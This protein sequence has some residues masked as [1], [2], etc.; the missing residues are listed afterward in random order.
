VI[1][2]VAAHGELVRGRDGIYGPPTG[3]WARLRRVFE[4]VLV[5]ARVR[6]AGVPVGWVR[7]DRDEVTVEAVST[8]DLAASIGLGR[9]CLRVARAADVALL[10]APS[11]IASGLRA[12]LRVVRRPF[13]VELLDEP[14]GGRLRRAVARAELRETVDAA[15]ATRF[16]TTTYLQQQFPPRAGRF[17]VAAPEVD[18]PDEL[19]DA[20]PAPIRSGDTLDLAFVGGFDDRAE[21]LELLITALAYTTR[22]HQ[23]DVAGDGPLRKDL[24]DFARR[25][26]VGQQLSFRGAV[27]D[28]RGFL[29]SRDLFVSPAATGVIPPTL[30]LAMAVRLPCVATRVGAVPELLAETETVPLGEPVAMAEV[31]DAL[32]ADAPRRGL[33][34]LANRRTVRE[35]RASEREIRLAAFLRALRAAG[36]QR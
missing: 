10:Q 11:P 29:R 8:D 5:L 20:P 28:V 31:I 24:V 7:V 27:L 36:E 2:A 22:P 12:A 16:I 1:V 21:G 34:A 18:L 4:R 17:T 23:L 9:A 14:T 13:A 33:V 3:G 35:F 25:T 6:S 26:G 15:V 32:A 19:F 30:L